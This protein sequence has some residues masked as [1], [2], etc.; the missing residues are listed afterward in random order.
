VRRALKILA[1]REVSPQ[2]GLLKSTLLQLDSTFSERNYGASSFFDFV[3]KLSQAGLVHLRHS[4]RS[5]M[6]ELNEGDTVGASTASPPAA[7]D[8]AAA[9]PPIAP[10]AFAPVGDQTPDEMTADGGPEPGN[11]A[12]PEIAVPT[13]SAEAGVQRAGRIL[14]AAMNARWPM[15]LRNVRQIL[16]QAEG[17]FDERRYGFGGL[18]DLLRACQRAGLVRIERDHRGGLRVFHGPALRA[19]VDQPR[20]APPPSDSEPTETVSAVVVELPVEP[21]ASHESA[22]PER[23]EPDPIP[24]DTTAA[25]LGRALRRKPRVRTLPQATAPTPKPPRAS[26]AKA[27]K[28]AP[29]PRKS[30]RSTKAADG[31]A[32]R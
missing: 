32:D 9:F 12:A 13:E 22:E 5:L 14:S 10:A 26:Q 6:V 21:T 30:S 17:G 31:G 16:R 27:A 24:I 23:A 20:S 18:M 2:A 4:G 19:L 25:L 28:K 29:A 3:Q 1:E 15:Y 8:A 11:G 7:P